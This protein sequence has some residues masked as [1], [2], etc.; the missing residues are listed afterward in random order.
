[1]AERLAY[2]GPDDSDVFVD[3]AAGFAV[4]HRRL[5]IV[6][7]SQA[8][9][10]PMASA[11]SRFVIAYNGEIYN[12]PEVAAELPGINW[13][14]HSDTEVLVEACARWGVEAAVTRFIGMFAFVL[15]DRKERT[16]SLVRDR[17]GIKPL[18]YG[19][20]GAAFVFASELKALHAFPGWQ[21]KLSEQA[22]A[23]YLRF[24]YVPQPLSVFTGIAKLAPGCIL[25]READ[26]RETVTRY[27]DPRERIK[28]AQARIDRR[29]LP[30]ILDEADALLA[31]AVKR[32]MVA[33]VPLGAFLSAGINSPTVV[34]LMQRQSPRPIKTFTIGLREGNFNEAERAGKIAKHLGTD[35]TELVVE[36]A[37]AQSVIPLLPDMFDEPFADYSQIPTY[38]VSKLARGAVTVS[39]SGDGGDE[40]FGGYTRYAA[41]QQMWAIGRRMPT[42]MR[43]A[44][45]AALSAMPPAAIDWLSVLAPG[46]GRVA[47]PGDKLHKA[48]DI[49][50][51]TSINT[52][53]GR[54]VSLWPDGQPVT[55]RGRYPWDDAGLERDIPDDL[56]R[57]RAMDLMTYL[58]DD[59]LTKLDRASMAVSLEGRVPILDHRVVEFAFSLPREVLNRGGESKWLL[60][61][62]LNRYVPRELTQQPKMGFSIPLGQWLAGALRDWAEDL[63]SEQAL[64]ATGFLNVATVRSVWV[65]QL[66]GRI[67]QPHHLWAIL[68]LQTWCRRW[69]F[70]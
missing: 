7:L 2:R 43:R 60:R 5:S 20:A 53:Y 49:F 8:G 32:R 41:L 28:S 44:I 12:A 16:L 23:A 54:L 17:V 52:M 42:G 57:L 56:A 3:E 66:A 15:W 25:T 47:H 26:G 68:M 65:A 19:Q 51:Q 33:D 37:E 31:D 50:G 35:H 21:P 27:W 22:I 24:G 63:L 11:D 9:H 45:G 14:G 59:I 55:D 38:L 1:M 48:A 10:Q 39:L 30:D 62:I 13:R 69:R 6:D 64:R 4:G 70:C 29:P 61:Q 67:N 18:Y 40:L 58:P 36:P 46:G 34:S